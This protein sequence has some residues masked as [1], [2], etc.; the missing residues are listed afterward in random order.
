MS[1]SSHKTFQLPVILSVTTGVVC[2]DDGL[3]AVYDLLEWV[4]DDIFVIPSEAERAMKKAQPFLQEVFPKFG[5]L[6]PSHGSNVKEWSDK[7]E[8][9]HGSWHEV[10]QLKQSEKK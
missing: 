2:T 7:M 3:P 6:H 5:N 4:M 9:Y 8:L 1:E 10:P